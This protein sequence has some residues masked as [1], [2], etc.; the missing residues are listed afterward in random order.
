MRLI[1]QKLSG[2]RAVTALSW[3]SLFPLILHYCSLRS[4]YLPITELT[5]IMNVSWGCAATNFSSVCSNPFL[6][7][8]VHIHF[9][10]VLNTVNTQAAHQICIGL[11]KRIILPQLYMEK[12]TVK[13]GLPVGLLQFSE[14]RQVAGWWVVA[15]LKIGIVIIVRVSFERKR[16]R[17]G[18]HC[19]AHGL[20]RNGWA[21]LRRHT[22]RLQIA[23][24]ISTR[25]TPGKGNKIQSTSS[26]HWKH[27]GNSPEHSAKYYK[28]KIVFQSSFE[29]HYW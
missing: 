4:L 21:A 11:T 9:F 14:Q 10:I 23:S 12:L 16:S 17:L 25:L 13:T 18:H 5:V 1:R 27:P 8:S 28:V 2:H 24:A 3:F 19:W 22:S 6:T 15:K 29:N 20:R 7:V 26:S